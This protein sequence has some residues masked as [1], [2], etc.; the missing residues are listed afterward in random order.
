MPSVPCLKRLNGGCWGLRRRVPD[1]LR[2]IVG[3]REIWKSYGTDDFREAKR[4]H[5]SEMA[6]VEAQFTD[7]RRTLAQG[8]KSAALQ[9]VAPLAEPNK[10][11]V[12]ALIHGWLH[13]ASRRIKAEDAP[14]DTESAEDM[15]NA[16]E[17]HLAGDAGLQAAQIFL[18]K[19]LKK[20][21]FAPLPDKAEQ[22]D[23]E[24]RMR[25]A[26]LEAVQ[27]DR[28]RIIGLMGERT[29]HS[30]FAGVQASAAAPAPPQRPGITFAELCQQY[31]SSAQSTG[32]SPKTTLKYK[33]MFR[34]LG[35]LLG[36]TTQAARIT[37]EDCRKAQS[38]LMT[39]PANAAQRYPGMKAPQAADAAAR[40]GVAIMHPKTVANYLDLLAALF[41]WGDVEQVVK[42]RDGNPAKSLNAAIG[43][44]VTA[45]PTEKRRPFASQELKAIFAALLYAGCK[46]DEAGYH[47]V[48]TNHPRRGRFWVPLIG[49]YAGLRLNEACQL[50]TADVTHVVD[51]PMLLIRA[52]AE[53]QRLKTAAAERRI[54]VHPE[55]IR[56]GFV[57]HA[58]RQ[59]ENGEQRLFPDLQLGAMDN[60]S[61]PFSKWFARFLDKLKIS[62]P[63]ATFHSFRHGFRDCLREA[64]IPRDIGDFMFGHSDPGQGKAY[65][66]G[67]SAPALAKQ[68]A[69][70]TYLG[71]D[72]SHLYASGEARMPTTP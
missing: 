31:A 10:D 55:L 12:E 4:R 58:I 71:L 43:K 22:A 26:M 44:A 41:R 17:V 59:R 46:D 33:G 57:A 21:G 18:P 38:V 28:D 60:Y 19:L 36:E 54:P 2:E 61:D 24:S 30:A 45:N 70:V 69:K 11:D 42:L 25:D 51:V 39:M 64:D 72:L 3:K 23:A 9:R 29:Y 14:E 5:P 49:L 20:F 15:R 63:G 66:E 37:R 62:S 13:A 1:Q 56:L 52:S 32:L 40:D 48:G 16:E 35:E 8:G 53:D 65:G 7:A 47:K 67:Y 34:V 50:R 68:I 6:A 27:R